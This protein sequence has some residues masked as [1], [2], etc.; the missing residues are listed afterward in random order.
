M[1]LSEA[2][3][4][5]GLSDSA[6]LDEIMDSYKAKAKLYHPDINHE[7]DATR[8]MQLLNEAFT[9]VRTN[10]VSVTR[11]ATMKAEQNTS[12][13]VNQEKTTFEE[14]KEEP[15]KTS[16]AEGFFKV[17]I[18]TFNPI[19]IPKYCPV[20]MRRTSEQIIRTVYFGTNLNE[21]STIPFYSCCGDSFDD[22]VIIKRDAYRLYFYFKNENYAE[23]F[24]KINNSTAAKISNE[25]K[26]IDD[27]SHT[28]KTLF[29]IPYISTALWIGVLFL[30][31]Y[32][33]D[34]LF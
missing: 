28:T 32:I 25:R 11:I 18:D 7:A 14:R 26:L 4:L 21:S 8:K 27:I 31:L 19:F 6:S 16:S 10:A 15:Y 29:N 13:T 23:F 12:S 1:T 9:L 34:L 5:L 17:V 20:C 33:V 30:I 24:A 22:Y 3:Q 2:Y